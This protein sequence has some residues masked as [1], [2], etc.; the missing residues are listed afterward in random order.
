MA[1]VDRPG[2]AVL[3][4]PGRPYDPRYAFGHGLS[5]TEFDVSRLKAESEVD[6]DEEFDLKLKLE[7]EGERDGEHT[8]S[9][10]VER[11]GGAPIATARQ[12][13][14]F[15]RE[16]VDDGKHRS[17]HL[18][19]DAATRGDAGH[20]RARLTSTGTYRLVVGDES[21]TFEVR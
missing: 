17:V 1:A 13:V 11:T 9:R 15:E 8:V 4:R 18:E 6:A 3:Q 12:L 5:Y 20:G 14:V 19:F 7:N 2:A 16:E 10:F 21:R